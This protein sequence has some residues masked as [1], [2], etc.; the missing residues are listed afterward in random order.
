MLQIEWSGDAFSSIT[1]EDPLGDNSSTA[2][3]ST[4]YVNPWDVTL[5][6]S[7]VAL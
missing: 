2:P 7:I 5:T 4:T 1:E 6:P 3:S